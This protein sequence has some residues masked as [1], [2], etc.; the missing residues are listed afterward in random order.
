MVGGSVWG[1]GPEPQRLET[2]FVKASGEW[3]RSTPL[4]VCSAVIVPHSASWQVLGG[5]F[6]TIRNFMINFFSIEINSV[7]Y[8]L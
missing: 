7:T 4:T 6:G 2:K 8:Y 1:N 3:F 5:Q